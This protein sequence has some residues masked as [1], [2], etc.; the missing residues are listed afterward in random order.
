MAARHRARELAVQVLFQL[1]LQPGNWR[2]PLQYHLDLEPQSA[3]NQ[4]FAVDLVEGAVSHASEID[5]MI[6]ACS[7]NWAMDQMGALERAVLRVATEELGWRPETPVAV[8]IDEAVQLAKQMAGEEAGKFVNGILGNLAR[9][10][11]P[12]LEQAGARSSS[13]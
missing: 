2:D 4:R 9:S 7:T 13:R 5:A 11:R 8:V 3:S 12:G 10:A 1:E 6:R